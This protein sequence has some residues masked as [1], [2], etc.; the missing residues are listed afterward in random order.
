MSRDL[1]THAHLDAIEAQLRLAAAQVDMLRHHL[2]ASAVTHE[3]D[4]PARCQG[5]PEHLCARQCDEARVDVGGM[6]GAAARW[7]CRGCGEEV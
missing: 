4:R 7:I 6:G 2:G 5:V 3:P 1:V